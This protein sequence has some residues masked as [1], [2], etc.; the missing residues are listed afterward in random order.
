MAS[1]VDSPCTF[2]RRSND[3]SNT[4]AVGLVLWL[5]IAKPQC[6]EQR[7]SHRAVL[8]RIL[9][10]S[11]SPSRDAASC[12]RRRKRCQESIHHR[13]V[14]KSRICGWRRAFSYPLKV[15]Q[16]QQ[17]GMII[18]EIIFWG[19]SW[20][21]RRGVSTETENTNRSLAVCRLWNNRPQIPFRG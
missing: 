19:T 7:C 18:K 14:T 13:F 17:G 8:G 5:E 1:L 9:Q 16:C 6:S 10:S 15:K 12:G 11:V 21:A 4:T 3:C 20:R 2:M